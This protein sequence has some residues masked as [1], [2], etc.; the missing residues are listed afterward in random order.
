MWESVPVVWESVS[1]RDFGSPGVRIC[2]QSVG[3]ARLSV[4]TTSL[5]PLTSVA[6]LTPES[7]KGVASSTG[8]PCISGSHQSLSL[9][10]PA[11]QYCRVWGAIRES[12]LALGQLPGISSDLNLT[13]PLE[14]ALCSSWESLYCEPGEPGGR[15]PDSQ[16]AAAAWAPTLGWNAP[17][18]HCTAVFHSPS[19][20]L[21]K[22]HETS[23][24][25]HASAQ[26]H[27]EGHNF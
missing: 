20:V 25:N 16:R 17:F 24:L 26:T 14:L 21:R 18:T 19:S 2:L 13:P 1:V 11:K 12:F 27:T 5:C 3:E 22:S 7:S 8:V 10:L 15:R 4:R 9:E 6:H 23:P